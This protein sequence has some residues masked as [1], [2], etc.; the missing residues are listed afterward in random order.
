MHRPNR[1]KE[2]K[3][4][5]IISLIL[6]AMILVT[7]VFAVTSCNPTKTDSDLQYIKDKGVLVVGITDYAPMDYKEEGSDKWIGFDAELAEAFAAS[8]GV[9][10]KFVVIDWDNKVAELDAK[11]IDLIWNGMTASDELGKKIDFSVSYAKNAQVAVVKKG[12]TITKETVS[13]SQIAVEGGSAGATVAEE[14]ING[15]NI[16]KVE[17]QVAALT[18]V[19]A[20]TSDV[21]IIDIT[22][23][24]S[25]VGKGAYADLEVLDG[26]SYGDEIFAVGLRTG[27]DVKAELDAFLKAK[28]ADGTMASLTEKYPVG[29]NEDALK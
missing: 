1:K 18:E 15:A 14:V 22:M 16:N 6:A 17:N 21:A 7:G 3:M 13:T 26:A 28:Y 20:G 5:K 19:A 12:S 2:T 10:C 23:A 24:Q 29:L 8:I 25:L 9:E 11:E 27:S 4:K